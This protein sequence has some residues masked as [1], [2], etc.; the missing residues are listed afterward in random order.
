MS[1]A[2]RFR[3]AVIVPLAAL[4]FFAQGCGQGPEFTP[5]TQYTPESLAQELA[6]RFNAL[7]PSG[8]SSTRARRPGKKAVDSKADEKSLTKSAAKAATKQELPKT[9]DDVLDDIEAKAGLIKG[10]ARSDVISK[11]I[12]ALS[13]DSSLPERDRQ[14]LVGKLREFGGG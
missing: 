2:R 4:L 12:D 11:M 10:I 13:G 5:E 7:S 9:V 14:M 6:F 3:P 1:S 8:K